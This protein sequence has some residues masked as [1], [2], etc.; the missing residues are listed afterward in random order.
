MDVFGLVTYCSS[1]VFDVVGGFRATF[2]D[3][4]Q[5]Y[6]VGIQS[7]FFLYVMKIKQ[8]VTFAFVF[9]D[10]RLSFPLTSSLAGGYN[11][12]QKSKSE[13]PF[14]PHMVDN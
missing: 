4:H 6:H 10:L 14:Y 8:V 9:I 12:P 3:G 11:Q 5:C 7:T 2:T 1:P 13:R